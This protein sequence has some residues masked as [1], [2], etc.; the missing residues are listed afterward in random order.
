MA[1]FR[2]WVSLD[3]AL[4]TKKN[5]RKVES[6]ADMSRFVGHKVGGNANRMLEGGT[7]KV[8]EHQD[9]LVKKENP[10]EAG[11]SAG[12]SSARP[13]L[14]MNDESDDNGGM[15]GSMETL[16]AEGDVGEKHLP[17]EDAESED[18]D[19]P[20]GLADDDD[21][22]ESQ[23]HNTSIQPAAHYPSEIYIASSGP[24]RST[25]R[26]A[27]KVIWQK[28]DPRACAASGA[29]TARRDFWDPTKPPFI[30]KAARAGPEWLMW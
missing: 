11:K 1:G 20:D 25:R 27:P 2:V 26:P 5:K 29:E 15:E 9:V 24:R 23:R 16:V 28:E 18:E 8:F 4:K 14:T 12:G 22:G 3:W 13:Q 21:K 19:N 6:R 7:N 17:V 10:T 30:E